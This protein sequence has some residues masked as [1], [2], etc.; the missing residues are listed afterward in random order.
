LAVYTED[1]FTKL[2]ERLAAGSPAAR[3][4]RDYSRMFFSQAACVTPDGQWRLRIPPELL[5]WAGLDG[6]VVI[7][8]VRDHMELWA[9]AKWELYVAR[10]DPHYDHL[11]EQ[12]LSTPLLL[13]A[14]HVPMSAERTTASIPID[15]PDQPR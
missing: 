12:A 4:V 6:E 8:G 15:P 3:E 13:A 9:A 5:Q 11:A 14:Q 10:C 1:A 7:V 2:A